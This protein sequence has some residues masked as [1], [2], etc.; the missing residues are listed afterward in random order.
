MSDAQRLNLLGA[1]VVEL[2]ERL[3]SA[4]EGVVGHSGAGASALVTVAQNP[5]RTI[6]ELRR[7][8]GL[9]H[10]ATVRVVDRLVAD[11][12]VL[13]GRGARGPAVALEV[14]PEGAR[15]AVLDDVLQDLP[16]EAAAGLEQ[17]LRQALDRLADT[18][19]PTTCRLCDMGRC[20]T[21]DCP[22]VD[23][24]AARGTPPP[25]FRPVAP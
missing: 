22:V 13:R 20:R 5:G 9:S 17:A 18:P 3:R 21:G 16:E 10:P 19:V 14:T 23:R 6:E 24:Q 8:I 1:V 15:R 7:A 4:V 11:G 2:G 25:P 12:L